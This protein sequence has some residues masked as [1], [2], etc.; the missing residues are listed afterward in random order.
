MWNFLGTLRGHSK[1]DLIQW[2]QN[3]HTLKKWW[4]FQKLNQLF[5]PVNFIRINS[6]FTTSLENTPEIDFNKNLK[7]WAGVLLP[8]KQDIIEY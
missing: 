6:H 5:H 8:K 4:N 3:P 1:I 7:I 2:K